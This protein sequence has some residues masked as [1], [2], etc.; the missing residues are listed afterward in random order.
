MNVGLVLSIYLG[1]SLHITMSTVKRWRDNVKQ[2]YYRGIPDREFL[3]LQLGL[4][5]QNKNVVCSKISED[6][7]KKDKLWI[8]VGLVPS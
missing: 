2:K 6:F 5:K 1:I 7:L 8:A 4:P 3:E